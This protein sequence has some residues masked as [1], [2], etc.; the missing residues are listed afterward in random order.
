MRCPLRA[1]Y[2]ICHPRNCLSMDLEMLDSLTI[3]QIC[4]L[5]SACHGNPPTL[6]LP[7]PQASRPIL[8]RHGHVPNQDPLTKTHASPDSSIAGASSSSQVTKPHR[9]QSFPLRSNMR[10]FSSSSPD[11]ESGPAPFPHIPL[12]AHSLLSS[13]KA[14]RPGATGPVLLRCN[15]A[16]TGAQTSRRLLQLFLAGGLGERGS[17]LSLNCYCLLLPPTLL[18]WWGNL[19]INVKISVVQGIP[20]SSHSK[21]DAPVTGPLVRGDLL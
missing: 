5:A 4:R 9:A 1:F 7:I 18:S 19:D 6:T 20:S 14:H 10:D 15:K 21:L 16:L 3:M 17:G 8:C 13:P 2:Y 12:Q 11:V